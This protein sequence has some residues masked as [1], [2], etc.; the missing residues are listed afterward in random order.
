VVEE[1]T[2]Q[3]ILAEPRHERTRDFLQ[4]VFKPV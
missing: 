1:G 4:R 3:Q 2:A